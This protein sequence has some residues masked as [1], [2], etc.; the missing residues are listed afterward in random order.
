MMKKILIFAMMFLVFA[1]VNASA[2]L[3]WNYDNFVPP[4]GFSVSNGTNINFSAELDA[5]GSS[6]ING[7]LCIT[8]NTITGLGACGI[9]IAP[10]GF[11]AGIEVWLH[12][13]FYGYGAGNYFWRANYTSNESIVLYSDS[14]KW[15]IILTSN[16]LIPIYPINNEN[17]TG[18]NTNFIVNYTVDVYLPN[19]YTSN[20]YYYF[21]AYSPYLGTPHGSSEMLICKKILYANSTNPVRT[22]YHRISCENYMYNNF[23]GNL[24]YE[25]LPQYNPKYWSVKGRY[26]EGEIDGGNL[27]AD[28]G[29]QQYNYKI[30]TKLASIFPLNNAV[31]CDGTLF[32]FNATWYNLQPIC[33]GGTSYHNQFINFYSYLNTTIPTMCGNGTLTWTY[34]NYANS[35]QNNYDNPAEIL[36][37]PANYSSYFPASISIPTGMT[38]T[39]YYGW[40]L[41]PL[42]AIR[43]VHNWTYTCP[44]G[45]IYTTPNKD[46]WYIIGIGAG[47]NITGN[48]SAYPTYPLPIN[49]SYLMPVLSTYWSSAFQTDTQGG[50]T[51]IAMFFLLAMAII[52]L[53]NMEVFAGIAVFIYGLLVFI[54]IGYINVVLMW[55]MVIISGLLLVYFVRRFM[56]RRN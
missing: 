56:L 8:V 44:N 50:L 12:P 26:L 6:T 52:V 3:Y 7:T 51:F 42:T 55:I 31:F 23:E 28:T 33:F 40:S 18:D 1:V 20:T 47:G 14:R 27:F 43:L 10:S 25:E 5:N 16:T 13:Y 49:M 4:D 29:F 36:G 32:I 9:A 19:D 45:S 15:N 37:I 38:N 35:S 21:Y 30:N 17:V 41:S 22:G 53:I 2:D 34:Y 54:R 39:T 24:F 46:F 48:V 11:S